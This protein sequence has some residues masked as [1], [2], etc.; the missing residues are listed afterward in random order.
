MGRDQTVSYNEA[1]VDRVDPDVLVAE[2][3]RRCVQARW[4][5]RGPT[6]AHGRDR[7]PAALLYWSLP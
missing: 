5:I 2:L 6:R 4:E 3:L 1:D 7:S